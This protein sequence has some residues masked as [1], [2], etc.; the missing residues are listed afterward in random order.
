[1]PIPGLQLWGLGVGLRG[2][3]RGDGLREGEIEGQ[4]AEEGLAG[5]D[6]RTAGVHVTCGH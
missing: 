5:Q 1:M 2:K 6:E 4:G 3:K